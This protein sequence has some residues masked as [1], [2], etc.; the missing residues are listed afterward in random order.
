MN[1]RK[2]H[3]IDVSKMSQ[4]E[5]CQTWF[6]QWDASK[7]GWRLMAQSRVDDQSWYKVFVF[8]PEIYR[9]LLQQDLQDW[10]TVKEDTTVDVSERLYTLFL[11]RWS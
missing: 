1:Q 7:K 2:V 8:A 9:W 5:L 6:R 10:A 11:M 3:R 4:K